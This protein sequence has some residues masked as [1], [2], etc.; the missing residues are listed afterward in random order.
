M[1]RSISIQEAD[2]LIEKNRNDSGFIIL[3]IRTPMEYAGGAFDGAINIDFYQ[4]DFASRI[5]ALDK[6]KTY[7]IYCRS[8]NRSKAALGLMDKMGFSD[9]YELSEGI[10]GG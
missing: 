4:P 1:I 2:S 6:N 3:D 10:I 7:L 9:V 8:G 5:E